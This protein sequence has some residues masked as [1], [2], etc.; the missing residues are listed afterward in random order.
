[1]FIS[2]QTKL[3]EP[4][5]KKLNQGEGFY[6]NIIHKKDANLKIVV[7]SLNHIDGIMKLYILQQNLQAPLL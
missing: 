2:S 4:D 1:M 3:K 6:I 7:F 5:C